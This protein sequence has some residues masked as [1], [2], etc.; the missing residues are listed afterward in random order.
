MSSGR[1]LPLYRISVSKTHNQIIAAREEKVQADLAYQKAVLG[2][3]C[4]GEEGLARYRSEDERRGHQYKTG[5]VTFINVLQAENSLLNA[6]P[7]GPVRRQVLS[8]PI[9][10]YKALGGGW[11]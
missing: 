1:R 9:S 11:T 4:D 3:F 5:F 10:I 8:D 7:A 2:A 6:R